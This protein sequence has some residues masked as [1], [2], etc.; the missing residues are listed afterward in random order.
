MDFN[1]H[2][3]QSRDM[4]FKI[5]DLSFQRQLSCSNQKADKNRSAGLSPASQCAGDRSTT[6]PSPPQS[7]YYVTRSLKSGVVDRFNTTPAPLTQPVSVRQSVVL[8]C[9]W[10]MDRM[11]DCDWTRQTPQPALGTHSQG[12]TTASLPAS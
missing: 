1:R 10:S 4:I 12:R 9:Y 6:S 2:H 3:Q 7:S 5:I 11:E 8:G